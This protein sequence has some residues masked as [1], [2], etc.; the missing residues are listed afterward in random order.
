MK[1]EAGLTEAKP[2]LGTILSI[3]QLDVATHKI[4]QCAYDRSTVLEDLKVALVKIGMGG[5]L[6]VI[7]V[8]PG[9]QGQ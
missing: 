1:E 8:P 6:L 4:I 7:T 9:G 2:D 5:R 3:G